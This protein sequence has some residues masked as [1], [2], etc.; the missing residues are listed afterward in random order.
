MNKKELRRQ[1]KVEEMGEKE[2]PTDELSKGSEDHLSRSVG[3]CSYRCGLNS[4]AGPLII[5]ADAPLSLGPL[6]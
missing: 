5:S 4:A 6:V 3:D 2:E 1:E